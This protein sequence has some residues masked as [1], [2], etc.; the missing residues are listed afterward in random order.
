M[1]QKI[2]KNRHFL[3]P[4]Q[5]FFCDGF[6]EKAD[7]YVNQ[8]TESL[9]CSVQARSH[10][11][12][13]LQRKAPSG[14]KNHQK[15]PQ[16]RHFFDPFHVFLCD[17]SLRKADIYVNQC[18]R[19]SECSAKDQSH[20]DNSLQRKAL[21]GAKNGKKSRKNRHFFNP[22]CIFLCNGSFIKGDI[23]VNQCARSSESSVGA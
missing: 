15:W 13:S 10:S 3:D 14:A 12:N 1:V 17:G 22:F 9:E 18:A 2:I 4:F 21:T 6:L 16:N 5:V 11:D 19:A 23:Y 8:C 7:L 20:S